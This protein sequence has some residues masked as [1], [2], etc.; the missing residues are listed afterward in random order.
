MTTIMC[1]NLCL[2]SS[3]E[4]AQYAGVEA[5]TLCYCG[6]EGADYDALGQRDDADCN[7]PC[8]GDSSQMCGSDSGIAVYDCKCQ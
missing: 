4:S 6:I 2:D 1:I 3:F 8:P 5:K 7:V